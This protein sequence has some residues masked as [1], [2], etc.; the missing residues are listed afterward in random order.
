MLSGA[1]WLIYPSQH[2]C[3]H[4]HPPCP[5][6]GLVG[7]RNKFRVSDVQIRKFLYA[8][9]TGRLGLWEAESAL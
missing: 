1:D 9:H 8:L 4:P 2:S 3:L 6:E 7:G 5:T